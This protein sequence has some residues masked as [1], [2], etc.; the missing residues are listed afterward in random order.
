MARWGC[1]AHA[2]RPVTGSKRSHARTGTKREQPE[3][4]PRSLSALGPESGVCN[5]ESRGQ[6]LLIEVGTATGDAHPPCNN[7]IP[8][9][10]GAPQLGNNPGTALYCDVGNPRHQC[11]H[12]MRAVGH[13]VDDSGTRGRSC[14]TCTV[15]RLLDESELLGVWHQMPG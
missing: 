4:G 8:Q 2:V 14:L 7:G 10:K 5:W 3:Q 9:C 6:G 1:G 12:H 13:R 15:H 11:F